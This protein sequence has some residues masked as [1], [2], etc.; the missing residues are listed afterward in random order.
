MLVLKA[1]QKIMGTKNFTRELFFQLILH[2]VVLALYGISI[3]DN[4]LSTQ[5][6]LFFTNY[7]LAAG[8]INYFLLPRYL[9][10]KQ[11]LMFSVLVAIIIALVILVE[12]LI[13]EPV[14]FPDTRGKGFPGF[15][16]TL[17]EV[18]PI[19]AILTGFK[20]AWDALGK[21]REVEVLKAAVEES[22]LQF[23]K[24]QI[25]PHFLFNNLNNLYAYAIEQSPKTP[26][27][28]LELS[29][30]LRYMLYECKEKYVPLSKEI[31]QLEN[32]TQL[33]QLQIEDRGRVNFQKRGQF[34]GYQIAPLIMIVFI[35]NAF[36]HSQSSQSKDIF[37]DISVEIV[38]GGQLH[39]LCSNNYEQRTNT[40]N[41][42]K[43]IGLENVKK[44]L[45]IL[46]PG[47]HELEIEQRKSH[48]R[49]ELIMQLAPLTNQEL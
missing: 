23:L 10:R 26:D 8:L 25:N 44:R 38:E 41:L 28:I 3:R 40:E 4:V 39:F 19:I 33:S 42:S 37:I 13:L 14:F 48:Y 24:S 31:R 20:F 2:T 46:Y 43:G 9:Y 21:Q 47:T 6:L 1:Y 36:K 27:I 30:V 12:E 11:H 18:T 34:R 45:D 32:F 5:E 29:G 7:A 15:L 49:V 35:E 22:E 17:V 16:F